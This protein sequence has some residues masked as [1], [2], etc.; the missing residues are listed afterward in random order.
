[1]KRQHR[2]LQALACLAAAGIPT[3]A[4]AAGSSVAPGAA[5]MKLPLLLAAAF[6][7]HVVLGRA[8][9]WLASAV[10]PLASGEVEA[11]CY[12]RDV[13]G[14]A[15]RETQD[16]ALVV[17]SAG[18]LMWLGATFAPNWVGAL[19][20][21]LVVGAVVL[22]MQRWERATASANFVW[23]Q[24][25]LTRKVRRI[26]IENIRDVA[27]HEEEVRGFTLLHGRR[28]RV[29]AVHLKLHDKQAVSLPC[30]DSARGLDDVEALANHVRARLQLRGERA[31]IERAARTERDRGLAPLAA[32]PAL[33][34]EERALRDEL[35][36]LRREAAAPQAPDTQRRHAPQAGREPKR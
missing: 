36:R 8:A 31:G 32:S 24:R 14:T 30:T 35:K 13:Y 33:S 17:M 10:A 27:V 21:G 28:N 16:I 6:A 11:V 26:A 3:C 4:L 2:L 12:E 20:A 18:A 1:M 22:D 7:A 19:G 25:G 15:Q 9:K 5:L 29:C 34:P 23:F